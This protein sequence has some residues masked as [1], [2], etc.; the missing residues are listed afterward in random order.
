[1]EFQ[2]LKMRP[3][4]LSRVVA[5]FL[6]FYV[7]TSESNFSRRKT[8]RESYTPGDGTAKFVYFCEPPFTIVCDCVRLCTVAY[9][10]VTKLTKV[11]YGALLC[12]IVYDFAR[13]YTIVYQGAQSA[14]ECI[15]A[16]FCVPNVHFCV[17]GVQKCINEHHSIF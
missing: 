10:S 8:S 5:C 3:E 16:H 15:M 1:M 6:R 17:P 4:T 11:F 9:D 2:K 13:L 12:T 7:D 14:L